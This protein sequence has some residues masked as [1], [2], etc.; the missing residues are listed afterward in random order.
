[1]NARE[2]FAGLLLAE[3]TKLRSVSRWVI[4]LVGAA[5]LT[6]GLSYLAASGNSWDPRAQK[7]FATGPS[8]EPVS[9]TFYFIHQPVTGD[10]TL[11]VRVASLRIPSDDQRQEDFG[12]DSMA[13][14]FDPSPFEQPAAGIM[15][16]DGT[17]RGTSYASVMLTAAQGVRM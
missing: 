4:T 5:V 9:D 12:P 13:R 6:I 17:Q 3:W 8:G 11:T 10:T 7:M 16:K 1:M 14:L 15:I 2:S